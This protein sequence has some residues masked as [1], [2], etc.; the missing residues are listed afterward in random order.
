MMRTDHKQGR[1]LLGHMGSDT[2]GLM[3]GIFFLMPA[4]TAATLLM[5][6]RCSLAVAE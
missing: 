6:S 5:P 4:R 2:S 3:M 1:N